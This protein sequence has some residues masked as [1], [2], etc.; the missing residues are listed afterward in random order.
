MGFSTLLHHFCTIPCHAC[1]IPTPELEIPVLRLPREE[2]RY[3]YFQSDG[4]RP[5]DKATD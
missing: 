2:L 1:H 4:N 5:R 3:R